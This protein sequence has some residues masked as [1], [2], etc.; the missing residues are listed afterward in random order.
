MLKSRPILSLNLTESIEDIWKFILS[1]NFPDKINQ[2]NVRIFLDNIN[3][4]ENILKYMN[5]EQII[6][7][8][9]NIDEPLEIEYK[10]LSNINDREIIEV[11]KPLEKAGQKFYKSMGQSRDPTIKDFWFPFEGEEIVG[12]KRLIKSEDKYLNAIESF[13]TTRKMTP[14]LTDYI[15]TLLSEILFTDSLL[16]YGRFIDYTNACISKKLYHDVSIKQEGGKK[17]SSKKSSK[18]SRKIK[19]IK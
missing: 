7:I 4:I 18:K 14:V 3:K 1:H 8:Y 19:L 12:S 17:K 16:N 13:K 5:R 11:I 6:D 10:K 15:K 2:T 9:K